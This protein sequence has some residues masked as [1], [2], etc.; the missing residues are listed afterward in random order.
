M[1]NFT[2]LC[3]LLFS[4]TNINL[5]MRYINDASDQLES[6]TAETNRVIS[7]KLRERMTEYGD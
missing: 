5:D 7:T 2:T 6:V 4:T 3:A 1:S